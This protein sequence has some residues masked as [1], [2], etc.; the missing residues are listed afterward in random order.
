MRQLSWDEAR[1][2][3]TRCRNSGGRVGTTN[4]CFDI[5]HLGHVEYLKAAKERVDLLLVAINS[6]SSVQR[7][8]GPSRPFHP[9]DA[10]TKVL[11]A[12]RFVDGVCLFEQ[13]TPLEWLNHVRPDVH[14]KGGDYQAEKLPEYELLKSWG[15]H[16]MILPFVDGY[17]TTRILEGHNPKK[18]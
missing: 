5:I 13:D 6:D 16:V 4:G 1:D 15:G 7:L 14:F 18:S 9:Q 12:V 8:K 2:L 11:S 10:R 17:S 3:A